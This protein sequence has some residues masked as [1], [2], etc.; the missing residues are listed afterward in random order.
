[1]KEAWI[2]DAARSP[3]GIGRVGK[4]SLVGIHPQRIL[5][6][7][8]E[9]LTTRTG[10][11]RKHIDDVIIACGT[12]FGEQGYCIA[13]MAALAYISQATVYQTANMIDQQRKMKL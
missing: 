11:D 13:R 1:M 5:A 2:I 12:Q 9:A 8:L 6:Q 4:G 10:M 3:R 7:L